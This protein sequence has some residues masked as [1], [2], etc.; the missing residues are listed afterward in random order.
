[1][2]IVTSQHVAGARHTLLFACLA[3]ALPA[4]AAHARDEPDTRSAS[5]PLTADIVV[6]N[7]ADAGAGSLR[8]AFTNALDGD[9]IGFDANLDCSVITL[10]TGAIVADA[11]HV[12]LQGPGADQLIVTA[13]YDD[14]VLSSAGSL[15]IRDI[16]IAHG[17]RD[18]GLGG[19]L[20]VGGDLRL[21][22]STVTGCEAGDG[23]N[24]LARGGGVDVLGNLYM[25]SSIISDSTATGNTTA[26]GG[27]AYVRGSA[28]IYDSTITRS[29]AATVNGDVRGGGLFASG[30]ITLAGSIVS[31]DSS[32]S[33]DG[34]AYGGGIYG[35]GV[36]VEIRSA[37]KITRNTAYSQTASAYG[38]GVSGGHL[39][40]RIDLLYSTLSANMAV[41]TCGSCIVA[42]G[43][44]NAFGEFTAKFSAVTGNE[45]R[46]P[47]GAAQ[48]ALGGGLRTNA[49][50]DSGFIALLNSTVSGNI[51]S[52]GQE[53]HG[54]GLAPGGSNALFAIFS[55]IAFNQAT[56]SGGGAVSSSNV[57]LYS[58]VMANNAAP[59]GN[60][61]AFDPAFPAA[62]VTGDHNVVMSADP[63]IALPPDTLQ[64]DP[65]LY[66]LWSNGGST[67]T[68]AL[69]ACSPA[70]DVGL[71]RDNFGDI[72]FDQRGDGYERSYGAAPDIG[73]FELQP[74]N[75]RIFGDGFERLPTCPPG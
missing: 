71:I 51:A 33:I 24:A 13:K 6:T 17:R 44:G 2:A 34:S 4:H 68:H 70:L 42:G 5:P 31:D 37:S 22:R 48:S 53:G 28:F 69:A 36:F 56:G 3:A 10:S 66:P 21:T 8:E 16:T 65:L 11:A 74:D 52:A 39:G 9:V 30:D 63:G 18:P 40:A 20:F 46:A 14:R 19:C 43:G 23:S 54:G 59:I 49:A 32:A 35:N 64:E 47:A 61:I 27:G 29:N 26:L 25:T 38:G 41:S 62:T 50:A 45:A 72:P 12:T 73:A 75:E 7:C 67:P 58:A 15:D 55:T 57:L 60:D 1:M